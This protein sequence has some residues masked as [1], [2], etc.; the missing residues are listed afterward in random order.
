[1]NVKFLFG[2]TMLF[3][4]T[5]MLAQETTTVPSKIKSATIY[6]NQAEV[7]NA[8]QVVLK[9]GLNNLVFNNLT[10]FLDVNSLKINADKEVTITGVNVSTNFLD[11]AEMP[12]GFKELDAKL[13]E[14]ELN[15]EIR[16]SY[17]KVYEEERS[18]IVSN[19][20][21][22]GGDSKLT[23]EDLSDL[24]N[25]YRTR[26]KEIE[27]KIIE[28]GHEEQKLSKEIEK[29]QAQMGD[30]RNNLV[31]NR[32]EVEVTVYSKAGQTVNFDLNYLVTNAGW[33]PTYEIRTDDNSGAVK[34]VYK[35]NV[36]QSTGIDWSEV[37]L[38]L[39]TGN[40]ANNGTQPQ[41]NPDYVGYRELR[42]RGARAEMNMKAM[43]IQ[44]DVTDERVDGLPPIRVIEGNVNVY[45]EIS[46][47]YQVSSTNRPTAVEIQQFNLTADLQHLSI[48]KLER[49]VFLLAGINGWEKLNL[50][51]GL[52]NVYY[53]NN[54]VGQSFIDPAETEEK[55]EVSLGR[56]KSV[57]VERKDLNEVSKDASLLGNNKKSFHYKF[58]VKNTKQRA[59][60][61]RVED[62]MPLSTNTDIVVEHEN[63]S[64]G[65]LNPETGII[66]WNIVLQAGESRDFELKYFIK[67][68]K[69]TKIDH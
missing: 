48:P 13:K 3:C 66:S 4:S 26:L 68:P 65:Q 29:Y 58:S 1:M 20:T 22:L 41:L 63:L 46:V 6:L 7:H 23:P 24:A 43:S 40:P 49:D 12:A 31:Q 69:G 36:F 55:L 10:P 9:P 15:L 38:T 54:F 34:L 67:F 18:L 42:T 30:R 45:F 35:A 19:K 61:I 27:I 52:A 47:P 50:L 5:V 2:V 37:K 62:Q 39:S 64:G 60:T 11:D 51:P 14:A 28:I 25:I 44:D 32:N 59:I 33:V 56:D 53:G 17:K 16:K 8:A 21:I 57:V